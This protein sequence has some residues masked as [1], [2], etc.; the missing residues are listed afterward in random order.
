M[1]LRRGLKYCKQD[2]AM[3]P[4]W[5]ICPTCLKPIVG[6]LLGISGPFLG[7]DFPIREGKNTIGQ[8]RK[9]DIV[10][11]HPSVSPMHAFIRQ[12]S[13]D[14]FTIADMNSAKGTFVN[15]AQINDAEVIDNYLV[16]FGELEFVFKCVPKFLMKR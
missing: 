11:K 12:G 7:M 15:N 3:H 5:K 4:S 6:W 10:L 14:V 16:R 13:D 8:M 9:N 2:H 1:A